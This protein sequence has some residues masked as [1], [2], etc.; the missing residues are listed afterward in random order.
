[1]SLKLALQD[2]KFRREA[3][4]WAKDKT[5]QKILKLARE[6]TLKS[7]PPGGDLNAR[8]VSQEN[9]NGAR[10]LVDGL[11]SLRMDDVPHGDDASDYGA[12]EGLREAGFTDKKIDELI[13]QAQKE[14]SHGD[15]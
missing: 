2:E 12:R 3:R 7:L 5:T 4:D 14:T 9:A 8:L 6:D 13:A 10:G 15:T 11:L 1:M